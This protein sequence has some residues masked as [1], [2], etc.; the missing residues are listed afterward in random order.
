M[1]RPSSHHDAAP[2]GESGLRRRRATI[3]VVA[4]L[5]LFA[6]VAFLLAWLM[7]GAS[8]RLEHANFAWLSASLLLELAA[9]AGYVGFFAA[10]FS[11][12]PYR[13]SVVRS[14]QIALGE[15]AG[16]AVVPTGIGG[17]AVRVWALL[18]GGTP[19]PVVA[20]RSVSFAVVF[21]IPYVAAAAALG[22]GALVGALPGRAPLA[23]E[24]APVA[25]V[26]ASVAFAGA[27]LV[28]ARSR[29][30]AAPGR[31]RRRLRPAVEIVPAGL[32]DTPVLARSPLAIAGA[33]GYWVLDCAAL[34]GALHAVGGAPAVSVVALA[35]M[36]GQLGNLAPLPGGIG[37][38]EP[39]MLG[40]LV[41]SGVATS[42]GAA[43]I[44]CYRAIALGVQGTTGALA[45]G[46]LAPA[47]A[48]RRALDSDAPA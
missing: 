12:A 34:W 6:L 22:L 8:R 16:F 5:V 37:G 32:H 17:P 15:L 39:I 7:P 4:T 24:L 40:V 9:C 26:V 46:T 36:L 31:W 20:L 45:L 28:L 48:S 35:Y 38:V 47:L 3:R 43:A 14:A 21:N 13:L 11:R 29:W 18:A 23:V 30:I 41:S 1:N 25:L 10:T 2:A 42:L 27:L 44:V 33:A 19:L